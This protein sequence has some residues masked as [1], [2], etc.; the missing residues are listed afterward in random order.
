MNW[1]NSAAKNITAKGLALDVMNPWRNSA[2]GELA[3]AAAVPV[4]RDFDTMS[5]SPIQAR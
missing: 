2:I 3:R 5:R 1:G 4:S